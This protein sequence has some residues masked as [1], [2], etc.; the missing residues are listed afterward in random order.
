MAEEQLE[1]PVLH[2]TQVGPTN[3]YPVK[4]EVATLGE[5]HVLAPTAQ[6]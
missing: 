1:A 6:I 4:Q 2:W 3:P 5:K